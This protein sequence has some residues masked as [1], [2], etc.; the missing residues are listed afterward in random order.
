MKDMK[1]ILLS[2]LLLAL[3]L[4]ASAYDIAVE[5]D[6]KV[7]IYYNYS[8]DGKELS[9][10]SGDAKYSGSVVIPEEVTYMNMPLK[11]TSIGNSAFAWCSGLTSVTIPNSVTSIRD[12]AFY[13]CSSLTSATIPNSVT[14]I[15]YE[16]FYG[17]SGLT[18]VTI[19]NSMT[20]IGGG[21]FRGCSGLTSVTIPNSVTSIGS[22]AFYG[23]CGLTS[24]TIP[25]SVTSIGG[26]AFR[27]CSGLTSVTI[28]NSV[29]SIGSEAFYGCS[30][31]TSVT[32]PNSVTSIRD[33]AFSDCSGLQKV[34]VEDITAWCNISFGEG[35]NPLSFAHHL[36]SDENTEIK[37]LI[38]PNSVTS[39]GN[40]AFYGCSGLTSVTIPNSV[41]SI[42]S[43]AF[44]GCS[45]L[46]SVTIPNSVT[47]IGDDTFW[48][49]SGLTSVTIG[50]SVTSIGS[51]AFEECSGLTS[52]TIPNSVTSIG[53]WAFSGC[54]G[55]T[56]VISLIENPF[57]IRGKSSNPQTFSLD[58]FNNATLYVPK[59]TIDKYKATEGWKDFLFI[60]EGDGSG[61]GSEQPEVKKCATPSIS[62]ADKRLTFSCETEGV[63]YIS[64]I[65]DVDIK[66]FYD[67][68]IDLSATYEISVYATKSGYVNSDMATATLVWT[69]AIFT[70]TTPETPSSA[71][72]IAETIPVL[73]SANNGNI[74]VTSEANG[75]AVAVYTVDGQLLGN[76]T[77][78]N[79]QAIVS[80][81]LQN[82]NIAVVNVGN[83]AVKI[84]M[85]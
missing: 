30:G 27:G 31:L 58:T 43:E 65:K 55:L 7:M 50:N 23:C 17:C 72:A 33:L 48:K 74:T 57:A 46:T 20:S 56:S 68:N 1:K 19:P 42:G 70:D 45:G 52:V 34:I 24:V 83:K 63:E 10:T 53:S 66:M 80:T 71:K 13:G 38:I 16:A 75:Q 26:G 14:S 36:Y 69:E 84:V 49:C 61:G 5:N 79:G 39:I 44:E 15:D 25:N 76:A 67:S 60:E 3:P 35:A 2:T 62:Y 78:S 40:K 54:S 9:I 18:S 21:A 4:L 32:I 81:T 59:G 6:D 12:Q 85:R 73:I 82:G 64:E 28:P 77:V 47:S 37:N 29:T 51:S 41:T 8:S 11:V 22:E